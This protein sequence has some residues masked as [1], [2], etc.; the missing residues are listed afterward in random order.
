MDAASTFLTQYVTECH[1]FVTS[2]HV[3]KLTSGCGSPLCHGEVNVSV[4]YNRNRLWN[5]GCCSPLCLLNWAAAPTFIVL[6]TVGPTKWVL[7]STLSTELGC[8]AH[9]HRTPGHVGP[10]KWVLQSTLST[11]LGCGAHFHRT[12]GHVGPTKWVL[13]STLSTELGC[14]AHFHRTSGHVGPTKWV[15][16]STLSTEVAAAPTK[17]KYVGCRMH[18]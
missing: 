6:D 17:T 15:L 5:C 16:T 1:A 2:R 9:F 12:S 10:T 4:H 18:V 7:Q 13:Q 3:C 8:G 14:G 11:E